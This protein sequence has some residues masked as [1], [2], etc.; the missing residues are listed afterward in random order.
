MLNALRDKKRVKIISLAIAAFFLLGVGALALSQGGT[1]IAS[2]AATSSVGVVNQQLIIT[3]HPDMAKA[4][5]TM[6]AEIEQAKKDFEEK[7]ANMNDQQKKDYYM[8]LQ[9]RL[10]QKEQELMGPILDKVTAAIK[11]VATAKG[12]SVVLDKQ[13]VVY[14][15]QDITDEVLKGFGK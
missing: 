7:A 4:K 8:Q 11:A 2:A 12:L 1:P 6:K 15:G 5:E 10:A 9:Q 3:Q 13:N 14:G